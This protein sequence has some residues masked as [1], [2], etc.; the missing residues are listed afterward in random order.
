MC[1]IHVMLLFLLFFF[2]FFLSFKNVFIYFQLF[3][4][5]VAVHGAFSSGG[6]QGLFLLQCMGFSLHWLLLLQSMGLG[7][8]G[9][10]SCR[11]WAQQLQHTGLVDPKHVKS[12][13]PGIEPVSPALVGRFLT[14]GPPGKSC[15]L[16]LFNNEAYLYRQD[17]YATFTQFV[18]IFEEVFE[19]F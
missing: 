2:S 18:I 14:T 16:F 3:W 15:F 8:P 19:S 10:G 5:F 12:S 17:Q 4:V 1:V 7:H 11:V 6:E 13:R 9:F